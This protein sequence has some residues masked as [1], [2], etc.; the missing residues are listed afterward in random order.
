MPVSGSFRQDECNTLRPSKRGDFLTDLTHYS[1]LGVGT[2]SS[3]LHHVSLGRWTFTDTDGSLIKQ[4]VP[5]A[6]MA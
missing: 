6:E 3:P 1:G 4:T 5:S 2:C